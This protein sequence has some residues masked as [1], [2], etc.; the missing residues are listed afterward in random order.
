[1]KKIFWTVLI[2]IVVALYVIA[3]NHEYAEKDRGRWKTE[4]LEK[5]GYPPIEE[6][7][8]CFYCT[9]IKPLIKE[10]GQENN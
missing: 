10:Y 3:E 7:A 6:P 2:L 9:Y 4:M 5:N 1:M 8:F